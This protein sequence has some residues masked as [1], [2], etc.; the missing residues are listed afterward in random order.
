MADAQP[1]AAS[2]SGSA[3]T[4]VPCCCSRPTARC[5][6]CTF[7]WAGKGVAAWPISTMTGSVAPGLAAICWSRAG[8]IVCVC[9]ARAMPKLAEPPVDA[10]PA[11]SV[12]VTATEAGQSV[13]PAGTV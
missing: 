9:I 12:P 13:V 2:I 4:G 5:A 3:A 8:S 1:A 10:L 7:G 11:R 6:N